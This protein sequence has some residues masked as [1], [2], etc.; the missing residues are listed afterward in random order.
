MPGT[1]L[2]GR[3]E[4][5]PGPGT[6]LNGIYEIDELV[7]TGGMG[8]VY[9]GRALET[10]SRV[11]IKMIR[12]DMAEDERLLALFR[13]EAA[14]LHL[15]QH[16]AIVRYYVFTTDPD[17]RCPYL[18]M[19][20]VEGESLLAIARRRPFDGP[21]VRVLLRRLA[22][23]LHAAH[24]VG[25]VHR[26]VSPDNIIL[27]DG[28]AAQAKI[29]DFG[30]ARSRLDGSTVIGSDFAGKANYVSPEQLGLYGGIVTAKS[31]MYGLGLTLVAALL[32]R[33]LDMGG[34]HA[35]VIRKR[36]A[37]P[38]LDMVDAGLR[39]I[40]LAMLQPRPEDRPASMAE[41]AAWADAEPGARA[42]QARPRWRGLAFA[43]LLAAGAAVAG[44]NFS[45]PPPAPAILPTSTGPAHPQD[46]ALEELKSV[47][48]A[49]RAPNAEADRPETPPAEPPPA[50]AA[51][52]SA[53]APHDGAF[54]DCAQCPEMVPVKAGSFAMGS[55]ADPTER[56]VHRVTLKRFALGRHPVT[57]R[58]WKACV[59][60]GRCAP[61]PEGE[62]DAPAHNLSWD[63]AQAY[64]GWLASVTGEPY[65]LPS[66]AEWEYAARA[67]TT[68]RYWWG[69]RFRADRSDCRKCGPAAPNPPSVGRFPANPAGLGEITGSVSQWLADC[70]V[71]S[72]RGA[73]ADGSART[74]RTCRERVLR[75]G[76]WL[77]E[78]EAQ[79]L[80][81]REFYD[82]TVRYPGHGLR[83]ARSM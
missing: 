34:S 83:V 27:P 39:P 36:Q 60:D 24:E 6:R 35:E 12:R 49:P 29:I 14:A 68:T 32:G 7:A 66:E 59:R 64:V 79:R 42:P 33:P 11:A 17:L 78:A 45:L 38:D 52:E 69:D 4:R 55:T 73:P 53:P 2:S 61:S 77:T 9:G 3:I 28:D 75:G 54:R 22:A 76:S 37:V 15:L 21:A 13:K 20:F 10:G 65:R 1:D 50:E 74:T 51:Q 70:W 16:P 44:V 56:P 48:D 25:V 57:V 58:E 72:Y 67:G 47:P 26:D 46:A 43:A 80:G 62:D 8:E 81:S 23:G 19:E 63:D 82:A 18:A 40:L 5:R 30:I 31:D 41:I 71:P